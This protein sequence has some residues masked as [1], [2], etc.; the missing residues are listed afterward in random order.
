MNI[1]LREYHEGDAELVKGFIQS[2]HHYVMTLDPIK[3]I[4]MENGFVE[5]EFSNFISDLKNYEGK[6]FIAE[7]DGKEVGF[8]FGLI[9]KQSQENLLEVIPTRLGV[10]KDL[11][12]EDEYRSKNIGTQLMQTMELYFIEKGC[13]SIWINVFAPNI[14]AHEFYK[15]HGYSDREIGLLKKL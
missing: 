11:Y 2:L 7:C 4:R 6:C 14:H 3:R 10:I 13:D 15:N 12:I 5:N 1:T 9:S 8:I